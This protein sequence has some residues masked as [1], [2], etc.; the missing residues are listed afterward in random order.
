MGYKSDWVVQRDQWRA[1]ND[2][3]VGFGM[4][5][6]CKTK[7]RSCEGRDEK[8]AEASEGRNRG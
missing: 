8:G 6:K 4:R 7:F 2:D 5:G 3:D 1:L